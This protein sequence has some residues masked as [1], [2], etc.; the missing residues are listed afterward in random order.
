MYPLKPCGEWF[1]YSG[2]QN[3]GFGADKGAKPLQ[4]SREKQ[5]LWEKFPFP[6]AFYLEQS[7]KFQGRMIVVELPQG[8]GIKMYSQNV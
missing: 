4:T 3:G 8:G 2:K 6:C 1:P 5:S 7:L